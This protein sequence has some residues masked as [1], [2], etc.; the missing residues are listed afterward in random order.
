MRNQNLNPAAQLETPEAPTPGEIGARNRILVTPRLKRF[1]IAASMVI[2]AMLALT[3]WA[4]SS[5]PGS[6]A[7]EGFHLTSIWCPAANPSACDPQVDE[8]GT[9]SI[10]APRNVIY[11]ANC[12]V[13]NLDAS[14]ACVEDVGSD[15]VR[16][17]LPWRNDGH[18]PDGFYRFMGLFVGD[19][20]TASVFTMR[21]VNSAIAVALFGVA[22]SLLSRPNRRVVTYGALVVSVPMIIYLVASINPSGWAITGV[23]GT[24]I[25]LHGWFTEAPRNGLQPRLQKW[26]IL[27]GRQLGLASVSLVSA[28][29]AASSRSDAGMFVVLVSMALTILHSDRIRALWWLALPAVLT[30]AIGIFGFLSASQGTAALGS[31]DGRTPGNL[32]LLFSNL[33]DFP[34]FLMNAQAGPLNWNDLVA[35]AVSSI[36]SVVFAT[37]IG[38]LGLRAMNWRKAVALGGL[39][40]AFVAI[41][42][43]VFQQSGWRPWEL[44]GRYMTPLVAVLI[45]TALWDPVRRSAPRLG[46]TQAIVIWLALSVGNAAMLYRQIRRFTTGLGFQGLNLNSNVYWWA[47]PVSPMATFILGSLGLSA[48][49]ALAF[50]MVGRDS[51][52]NMLVT[53][54]SHSGV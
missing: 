14:G 28:A 4:T 43:V 18:Y 52:D 36:P 42:L 19:N 54:S 53:G 50:W 47:S 8:Y 41:P 25:G 40:S 13:N 5:P 10:L 34:I 46:S 7:D 12:L 39:V 23:V 29:I 37:S 16:A 24:W 33:F 27:N 17:Q 48:L 20:L 22:I 38:F 2:A 35:P 21:I 51:R 11:G 3:A 30:S 15:L 6:S 31:M 1:G 49:V 9:L 45:M 44:A 26:R 32:H